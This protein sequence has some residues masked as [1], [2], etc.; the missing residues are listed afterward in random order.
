[1]P[2]WIYGQA[3]ITAVQERFSYEFGPD[4][5][6]FTTYKGLLADDVEAYFCLSPWQDGKLKGV[7]TYGAD[8][9]FLVLEGEIQGQQMLW[10][11]WDT[12]GQRCGMIL[13]TQEGNHLSGWWQNNDQD[14][15]LPLVLQPLAAQD[16]LHP[17]ESSI[18]NYKVRMNDGEAMLT[19]I[20]DRMNTRG[21]WH[22]TIKNKSET[23]YV[24]GYCA[25]QECKK[26]ELDVT[27]AAGE[28]QAD[29]VIQD[30]DAERINIV[31]R[32]G[33][34][35]T[36]YLTAQQQESLILDR[37]ALGGYRGYVN[38]NLPPPVAL[39]ADLTDLIQHKI[40]VL[41]ATPDHYHASERMQ[42]S[43]NAWIEVGY[44]DQQVFSGLLILHSTDQKINF[45]FLLD[46]QSGKALD[47]IGLVG[48]AISETKVQEHLTQILNERDVASPLAGEVTAANFKHPVFLQE[49]LSLCTDFNSVNGIQRV[50]IPYSFFGRDLLRNS[51]VKYLI[52]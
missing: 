48:H 14:I 22:S 13:L 24:R 40:A 6:P 19:L 10:T 37:L 41:K 2:S 8:G 43:T 36:T 50:V 23:F 39:S 32:S 4:S 47:L 35:K 51:L 29:L 44:F 7:Y 18:A 30:Q 52:R 1:M 25:D 3:I 5:G 20:R 45:P 31:F 15:Q 16:T 49:G 11:E 12:L 38:L 42:Q 28:H 46:M 27:N 26:L 9:N 33:D 34:R 17:L 21:I